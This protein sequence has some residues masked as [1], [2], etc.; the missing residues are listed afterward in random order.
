MADELLDAL[1]AGD[2][3]GA[4]AVIERTRSN[5]LK[6]MIVLFAQ[7]REIL[8]ERMVQ[9]AVIVESS[10]RLFGLAVD[11]VLSVSRFTSDQIQQPSSQALSLSEAYLSGLAQVEQKSRDLVLLLNTDKLLNE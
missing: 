2:D 4:R 5:E 9:I 10:G 1:A 8:L 7:T 6:T 11:E 3:E